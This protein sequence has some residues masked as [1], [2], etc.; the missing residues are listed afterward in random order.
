MAVGDLVL[1]LTAA[2]YR[3]IP[4]GPPVR[5]RETGPFLG[6]GDMAW[7]QIREASPSG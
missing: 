4:P 7:A 3:L 2:S 1:D 6:A 5:V